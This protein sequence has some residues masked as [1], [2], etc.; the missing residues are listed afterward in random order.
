MRKIIILISI[1]ALQG[2]MTT[3]NL[4]SQQ[5]NYLDKAMNQP[6]TFTVDSAHVEKAWGWAQSYIAKYSSMKIQN[7][8]D[9]V[10]QTYNPGM[11]DAMYGYKVVKTDIQDKYE[12]TVNCFTGNV[13]TAK[14]AEKN[15]HILAYYLK[16]GE[17]PPPEIISK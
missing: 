9:Y 1:F 15:A 7:A 11:H 13:F 2:C 12:L 17:N 14:A 5:Q 16:T 8:T 4:T 6:L 10:I 3:S